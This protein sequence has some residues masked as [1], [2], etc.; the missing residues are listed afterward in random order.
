MNLEIKVLSCG[1]EIAECVF[2]QNEKCTQ[3][4]D[5][6]IQEIINIPKGIFVFK[7]TPPSIKQTLEILNVDKVKWIY[8]IEL[9][10]TIVIPFSLKSD[11]YLGKRYSEIHWAE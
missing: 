10:H 3:S 2:Q 5:Q 4:K 1:C 11:P 7:C 9:G 6:H 8:Q